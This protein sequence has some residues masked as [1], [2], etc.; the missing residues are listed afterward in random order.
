MPGCPCLHVSCEF[1]FPVQI[2]V[3]SSSHQ[4]LMAQV[5]EL[6]LVRLRQNGRGRS[7]EKQVE[8]F[9]VHHQKDIVLG[10]MCVIGITLKGE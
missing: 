1:T 7:G 10:R 6:N 5:S 4:I 8:D 2:P 3:T 9:T